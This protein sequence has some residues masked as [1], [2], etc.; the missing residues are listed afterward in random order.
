MS[1]KITRGID[2]SIYAFAEDLIS[3]AKPR[4]EAERKSYA[5]RMA[6]ALQDAFEDTMEEF[7]SE[8][9]DLG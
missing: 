3:D 9:E 6:I 1:D 8:R 2:K 7:E 5:D 4:D